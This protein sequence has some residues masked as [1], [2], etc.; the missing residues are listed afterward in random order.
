MYRVT[1][2]ED[3]SSWDVS[4]VMDMDYMFYQVDAFNRDIG[5]WD[6][7]SVTSMYGMFYEAVSF[8]QDL[9][10]WCVTNIDPEPSD[11]ATGANA[12]ALDHPVWGTCP[13]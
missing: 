3:L 9:S 5:S 8:D 4:S 2:N 12:W 11:F 13:A 1:N 6:V 10:G 7:S